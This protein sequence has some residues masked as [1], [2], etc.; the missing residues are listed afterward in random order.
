[1]L[2]TKESLLY[3]KKYESLLPSTPKYASQELTL[4][5]VTKGRSSP[6]HTVGR[7]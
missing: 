1:M 6:G 7:G 2:Y 3:I 5:S 4:E